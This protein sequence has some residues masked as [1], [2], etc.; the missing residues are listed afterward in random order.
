M[1]RTEDRSM[2]VCPEC[3]ADIEIDEFDVEKGGVDSAFL[4]VFAHRVLGHRALAV[5]ADSE[6]LSGEQREL[7]LDV[8]RRFGFPHRLGEAREIDNP[9]YARNDRDRCYSCKSGLFRHP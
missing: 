8:A 3:E 4:A 6:S 9:L 5:T 1:I 2:A 7:A